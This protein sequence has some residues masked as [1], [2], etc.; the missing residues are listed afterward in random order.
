MRA[1]T[2]NHPHR[3]RYTTRFTPISYRWR[4]RSRSSPPRPPS[5]SAFDPH[6]DGSADPIPIHSRAN[7][8]P[9]SSCPG[10]DIASS[11]FKFEIPAVLH[12]YR[13][14]AGADA[15][16]HTD[17][18]PNA[19]ATLCAAAAVIRGVCVC[20]VDAVGAAGRVPGRV[21]VRVCVRVQVRVVEG[22]EDV[23][24][25][26]AYAWSTPRA[27]GSASWADAAGA[28]RWFASDGSRGRAKAMEGA[29]IPPPQ[30]KS[31]LHQS[32][33][34]AL[35]DVEEDGVE[36]R[37]EEVRKR[38]KER[39]YPLLA[40]L[41][42]HNASICAHLSSFSSSFPPPALQLTLASLCPRLTHLSQVFSCLSSPQRLP[43]PF[44]TS[45]SCCRLWCLVPRMLDA[46]AAQR[47]DERGTNEE[48]AKG[49]NGKATSLSAHQS[50]ARPFPFLLR[51]PF[52][53]PTSPLPSHPIST[54]S[55]LLPVPTPPP[56]SD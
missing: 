55:C 4:D 21:R 41:P 12:T 51:L 30:A 44:P 40:F 5:A 14:G 22:G 11:P 48:G 46:C 43:L 45:E 29:R 56:Q 38:R 15:G 2:S 26:T 9:V 16:A 52:S 3:A 1:P 50:C 53:S 54:D 42:L 32:L 6:P 27:A 49:R 36:S 34:S 33:S 13:G 25:G 35:W 28:G 17:S 31:I 8:V 7:P 37:E 10:V 19:R 24:T 23:Q 47:E 18:A 20:A 39:A